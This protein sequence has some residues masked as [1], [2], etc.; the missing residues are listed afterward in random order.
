MYRPGKLHRHG[1]KLLNGAC[2]THALLD[3]AWRQITPGVTSKVHVEQYFEGRVEVDVPAVDDTGSYLALTV[4]V[5]SDTQ[6]WADHIHWPIITAPG[7]YN[8]PVHNL[9]AYLRVS[10]QLQGS[11]QFG[12]R[13][14]GKSFQVGGTPREF[15]R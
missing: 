9:G 2:T 1:P 7:Y 3:L 15:D 10:Y 6:R 5:S 11:L 8:I 4:E 14:I 13:F 12:L